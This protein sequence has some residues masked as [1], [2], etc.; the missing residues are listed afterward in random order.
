M[1]GTPI[2]PQHACLTNGIQCLVGIPVG[3]PVAPQVRRCQHVHARFGLL[4]TV[5]SSRRQ[6]ACAGLISSEGEVESKRASS[7][8]LACA[9]WG[10]MRTVLRV[11]S[12]SLR[13]MLY[14]TRLESML[15]VPTSW[16]IQRGPAEPC[17]CPIWCRFGRASSKVARERLTVQSQQTP[18]RLG[19]PR[20]QEALPTPSYTC[21]G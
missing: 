20:R 13:Q 10:P 9:S 5:Q 7:V 19:R 12:I 15:V 17:R 21:P 1:A 2:R 4:A 11:A 14:S 6:G 3:T 16:P 8:L 18:R